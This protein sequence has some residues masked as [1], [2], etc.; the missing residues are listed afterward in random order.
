MFALFVV[1]TE[2]SDEGEGGPSMEWNSHNDDWLVFEAY[3]IISTH[4]A[5]VSFLN[6]TISFPDKE[7]GGAATVMLPV[8]SSVTN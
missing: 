2:E 7:Q 6:V 5:P 8:C 4:Q 1:Q 3:S